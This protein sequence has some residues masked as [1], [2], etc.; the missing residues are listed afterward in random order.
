MGKYWEEF[1]DQDPNDFDLVGVPDNLV[2]ISNINE[3]IEEFRR[4]YGSSCTIIVARREELVS[5]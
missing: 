5:G 4:K 2:P 1:D 3:Q